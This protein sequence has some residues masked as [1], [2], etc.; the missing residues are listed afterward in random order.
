MLYLSKKDLYERVERFRRLIGINDSAYPLDIFDLC[1]NKLSNIA[2]GKVNFKTNDLRGMA[3]IS[4]NI[5]RENHVILVNTN[6]T[7]AEINYHATHEVMHIA[8]Q[9]N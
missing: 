7:K 1:Q 2:I 4:N 3:F 6:K 9:N 5:Q 8:M